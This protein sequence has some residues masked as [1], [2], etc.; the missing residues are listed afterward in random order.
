M[1]C[2]EQGTKSSSGDSLGIVS[3]TTSTDSFGAL[4]DRGSLIASIYIS[5]SVSSEDAAA[6]SDHPINIH[7]F[8]IMFTDNGNW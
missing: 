4:Q 6:P 2:T 3:S 7:N 5:P 8:T 1:S